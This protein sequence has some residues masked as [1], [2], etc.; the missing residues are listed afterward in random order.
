MKEETRRAIAHAAV[1][2][3][4]GSAHGTV[5]SHAAARHTHFSGNGARGYDHDAGAHVS[6][7]GA[8]LY[9]HGLGAHI[10]LDVNG[11]NFS[12]YDHESGSHFSGGVSGS[13]VQIYD[14]GEGQWFNYN[15]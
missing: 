4:N 5:Y 10:T 7:S 3:V 9:H 15:A 12:G 8:G 14:H 6:E 2:R 11:D 13:S 1:A